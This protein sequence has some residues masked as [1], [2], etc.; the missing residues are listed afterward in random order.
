MEKIESLIL[1]NLIFNED[2]SKKT[3]PYLKLEYFVEK[4]DKEIFAT[5]Y[6]FINKYNQQPSIE[7]LNIIVSNRIKDPN[8]QDDIEIAL[9]DYQKLSKGPVNDEWLL[10]ETE[11]FCQDQAIRNALIE[12]LEILQDK[13]SKKQKGAI[14]SILT[15]ALAISFDNNVGHDYLEDYEERFE[16]Y[17]KKE[18][19]IPFHI[20]W[21][22]KITN[23]GVPPKTLNIVM[24]GVN[25]GKTLTLC[26]LATNYLQQ[27]KN[28]FYATF[29]MAPEEISKRIDAN[30]FDV[31]MDDID[32]LPKGIFDSRINK[33]KQKTN[34]KLL[35]KEFSTGS[36]TVMDIRASLHEALLKKN[37]KPDIILIDY[38][39]V[40]A[41]ARLKNSSVGLYQLGKSIAEEI[42][43]LA[44]ETNTRVWTAVQVNRSGYK[45]SAPD[46]ADIGESF[47]IAMT[48]D[49]SFVLVTN[50]ELEE[51]NQYLALQ[52]KNRYGNVTKYKKHLIGVSRE[53]QRLFNIDE[54][55]QSDNM[56]GIDI[57]DKVDELKEKYNDKK[58]KFANFKF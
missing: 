38:I 25:V 51:L 48:A 36:G 27:G 44:Q 46:M 12:S 47:A 56:V 33:L 15:D 18:N 49:F 17:H 52:I 21:L 26:D 2:F 23:G 9:R 4:I 5:A 6:E 14:P 29:E 11:K 34:G 30:N 43:G 32:S 22:N 35:V 3:L 55:E 37:F 39:G 42:R 16:Y 57:I 58:S 19:R 53:K 8:I 45:S 28:V 40:M 50:E 10:Q 1:R 20:D 7:A 31:I 41:S 54:S 13:N 24:A